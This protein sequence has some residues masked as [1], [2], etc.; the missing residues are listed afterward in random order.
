MDRYSITNLADCYLRV[1]DKYPHNQ[2][3]LLD[4]RRMSEPAMYGNSP[5]GC[6]T[7]TANLSNARHQQ[8]QHQYSYVPPQSHVTHSFPPRRS[9]DTRSIGGSPWKEDHQLPLPSYDSIELE[10]PLSPLNPTFSGGESPPPMG[11]SE[12]M[13][14]SLHEDYGPSPP[15]TGTSTSSNAPATHL[16]GHT[17]G[18]SSSPSN[19]KQ[20]SFVSLPGN[21]LK[22]R[23]RRRYDEIERLYRC[24]WQNC[25]KSYGTLNHLNA[26]ITMQKH[27]PKRSPNEFK[28]LRKQWRKAKKEEA[29]TSA[30]DA[31]RHGSHQTPDPSQC[32]NSTH[33]IPSAAYQT[34]NIYAH[35]PPRSGQPIGPVD[36][37][38]DSLAHQ[39]DVYPHRSQRYAPFVSPQ[40]QHSGVP[41]PHPHT[42]GTN[43]SN[44]HMNRLPASSTLLTPLPGYEPS[45]MSGAPDFGP[46]DLYRSDGRSRTHGSS[47]S[48]GDR[49]RSRSSHIGF[50]P[51]H[52]RDGP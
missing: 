22:K 2:H 9:S 46:Y 36:D 25:T 39:Q 21:V 13:F 40:P 44:I 48:H 32:H 18:E 24:S 35:H 29:E 15:G 51:G 49:G 20:Y 1:T 42:H 3:P 10:E 45:S 8:L 23:P 33:S 14:G 41:Y 5:N 43:A 38:H 16:Q 47:A 11:M 34:H 4:Q 50:G 28:E 37:L 30:F 52:H 6:P 19:S 12:I 26:H 7:N 17:A 31:A 27:G